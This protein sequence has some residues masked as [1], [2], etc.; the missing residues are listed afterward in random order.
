MKRPAAAKKRAMKTAAVVYDKMK[1]P[2]CP[3]VHGS[4]LYMGGKIYTNMKRRTF[5]VIRHAKIPRTERCV[6]WVGSKPTLAEW[7]KSLW[8]VEEYWSKQ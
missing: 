4:T 7:K 8:L 3:E 2:S 1:Q 5:R 6:R